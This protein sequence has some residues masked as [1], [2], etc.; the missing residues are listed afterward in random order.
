MWEV[1]RYPDDWKGVETRVEG[2]M[3]IQKLHATYTAENEF[4][5]LS[6]D[7]RKGDVV[8]RADDHKTYV[9]K[10]GKNDSMDDWE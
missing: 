7:V 8:I 10:T 1:K 4:E 3:V 5:Q 9:N 2:D 6:L